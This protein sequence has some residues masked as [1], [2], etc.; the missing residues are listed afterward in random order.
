MRGSSS[1]IITQTIEVP[2]EFFL[3]SP[4]IAAQG[5]SQS[6][7]ATGRTN[8]VAYLEPS[9][10]E[11][12]LG[13]LVDVTSEAKGEEKVRV[14]AGEFRT[15]HFVRNIGDQSSEWWID[16]QL[17]VP[18]RSRAGGVDCILTSVSTASNGK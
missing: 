6:V 2:K 17:G 16:P 13:T 18:V 5:W 7:E 1:G 4:A 9:E 14:P 15:R 3:C 12:A 11:S 8:T 10:F